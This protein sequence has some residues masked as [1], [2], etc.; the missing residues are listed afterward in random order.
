MYREFSNDSV[1]ERPLSAL[2]AP[3]TKQPMEATAPCAAIIPPVSLLGA[4]SLRAF[5]DLLPALYRE[6]DVTRLPRVFA[7]V[8]AQLVRG[9]SHG[10]VVHDRAR[11]QRFWHLRP[12]A[13]EA[14]TDSPVFFA[15]F[16][17]CAPA[18]C[19]QLDP[20]RTTDAF[21]DFIRQAG[22]DRAA[23][24][25]EFSQP[26]RLGDEPDILGVSDDIVTYA[27]VLRRGQN[28]CSE[29]RAML[30]A[31]RPHFKQ[32]WA[33]ARVLSAASAV[34]ARTPESG[35]EWSS[36]PLE[37]RLGLT[38]REAEVLLWVA[39]GKTNPEVGVILGIRSHTVRTHLERVFAKL[40]VETRHAAGVYAM[41]VLGLPL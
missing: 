23:I 22:M 40:G 34:D 31:L 27:A 25:G 38:P 3:V 41:E 18:D 16:D 24:N 17:E 36:L 20:A 5:A 13:F 35:R 39:Q 30:H 11:N 37:S 9:E 33:N 14:E 6:T 12:A 1:T 15:H 8:L 21:S 29:D 2:R 28:F 26:S 10:V 19:R 32:A 4:A 7:D